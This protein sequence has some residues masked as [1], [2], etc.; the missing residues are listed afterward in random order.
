MASTAFQLFT[1]GYPLTDIC[2]ALCRM[3]GK[4]TIFVASSLW[5]RMDDAWG[6]AFYFDK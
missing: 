5:T 3:S 4:Q 6:Y 2:P 1:A